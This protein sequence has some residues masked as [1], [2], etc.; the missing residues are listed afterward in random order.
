MHKEFKESEL[1]SNYL[2]RI[3]CSY[4][5]RSKNINSKFNI[6]RIKIRD[7]FPSRIFIGLKK[8]SW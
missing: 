2:L 6:S 1:I 5:G 8:T 4:S 3:F 7:L